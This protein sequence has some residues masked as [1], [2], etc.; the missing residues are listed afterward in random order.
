MVLHHADHPLVWIDFQAQRLAEGGVS[1]RWDFVKDLFHPTFI[2]TMHGVFTDIISQ[3]LSETDWSKQ[4]PLDIQVRADPALRPYLEEPAQRD[5]I[6][7][8][9]AHRLLHEGFYR[10]LLKNPTLTAI[11]SRDASL[12]YEELGHVVADLTERINSLSLDSTRKSKRIGI[13]VGKSWEQVASALAILFTG[14]SYV[15]LDVDQPWE[16]AKHIVEDSG[17][18]LVIVASSATPYEAKQSPVPMLDI[19][20][21]P[22]THDPGQP[23]ASRLRL[24]DSPSQEE[25]YGTQSYFFKSRENPR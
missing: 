21:F 9:D 3:T 13:Y 14:H 2:Q 20:M 17:C 25:A 22:F 19:S 1:L 15:P 7:F 10:Q 24:I 6:L 18:W 11:E 12:T 23:A 5:R 16:R 8:A 4:V